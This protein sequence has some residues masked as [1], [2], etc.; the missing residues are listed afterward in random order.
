[1][2]TGG[3]GPLRAIVGT[4]GETLTF[5]ME[6]TAP[7]C[8]GLF[9]GHGTVRRNVLRGKYKGRDCQGEVSDGRLELGLK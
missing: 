1:M 6:N 4:D 5:H 8:P 3:G 7:E 9:E 2:R